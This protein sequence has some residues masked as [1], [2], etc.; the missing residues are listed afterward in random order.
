ML[1]PRL[2]RAAAARDRSH[3]RRHALGGVR[4][5]WRRVFE[6][7]AFL[8]MT[9]DAVAERVG[10]RGPLLERIAAGRAQP[11]S[12]AAD[13]MASLCSHLTS[14]PLQFLPRTEVQ[15][16]TLQPMENIESNTMRRVD[17]QRIWKP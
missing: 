17:R 14:K 13:R 12:N 4:V 9:V 11:S 3:R 5:G 16:G 6:D 8:E 2:A 10:L 7:F 1:P 15:A